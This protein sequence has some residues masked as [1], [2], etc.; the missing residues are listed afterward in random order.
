MEQHDVREH[1]GD[2]GLAER[3]RDVVA[4]R[5]ADPVEEAEQ[6]LLALRAL[7]PGQPVEPRAAGPDDEEAQD[8]DR[9]RRED[10]VHEPEPDVGEDARRVAHPPGQRRGLLLQLR[11]DVV[12]LLERPQPLVLGDE[13]LHVGG[14][15][16]EVLD[17]VVELLDHRR[18]QDRPDQDREEDQPD[19]DEGDRQPALHPAGEEVHRARE[20][21]GEEAGDEDPRQR[22]AQQEDQP[23]RDRDQHHDQHDPEDRLGRRGG[24]HVDY[25]P[26]SVG[27]RRPFRAPARASS[28]AGSPRRAQT[29]PTSSPRSAVTPISPGPAWVPMTGPISETKSGGRP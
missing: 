21:D 14:V 17:Q 23:Q 10:R 8:D 9:H 26:G 24:A 4:D 1:A 2:E 7:A 16:G 29:G 20:R 22:P 15:R 3:A 5:V 11:R 28:P 13:L 19:V 18:D 27:H 6:P 25:G 12:V